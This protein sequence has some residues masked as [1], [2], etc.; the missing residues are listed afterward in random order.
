[1]QQL[2]AEMTKVEED[3]Q[4]CWNAQA[5][6]LANKQE[7]ENDLKEVKKTLEDLVEETKDLRRQK[8]GLEA[9]L[10]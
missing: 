4:A 7:K 3:R 10:Q 6:A 9:A 8:E 5:E 2:K 1:M